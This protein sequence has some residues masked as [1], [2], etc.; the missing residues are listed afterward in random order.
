MHS[1]SSSLFASDIYLWVYY[2]YHQRVCAPFFVQ[3]IPL[4]TQPAFS[5]P[6]KST[7]ARNGNFRF[8]IHT[9]IDAAVSMIY[10]RFEELLPISWNQWFWSTFLTFLIS[11]LQFNLFGLGKFCFLYWISVNFASFIEWNS[12]NAQVNFILSFNVNV[13]SVNANFV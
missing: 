9:K 11:S 6:I 4:L 3:N 7:W 13:F 5:T 10:L 12:F 2:Y 1:I 8:K